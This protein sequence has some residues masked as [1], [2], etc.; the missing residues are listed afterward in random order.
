M[1]SKIR[2]ALHNCEK[3]ESKIQSLVK[4]VSDSK[5]VVPLA[6]TAGFI[7]TSALVGPAISSH[8]SSFADLAKA[9]A[10]SI[11]ALRDY[12][13]KI[14][15]GLAAG[16]VAGGAVL[17]AVGYLE[18][19]D[20]KKSLKVDGVDMSSIG[21]NVNEAWEAIVKTNASI[22][23]RVAHHQAWAI[24]VI[25]SA[26]RSAEVLKKHGFNPENRGAMID[27]Q[28]AYIQGV[29]YAFVVAR[30]EG[31]SAKIGAMVYDQ[32]T[33]KNIMRGML[34]YYKECGHTLKPGPNKTVLACDLVA[35]GMAAIRELGK[36]DM[37]VPAKA[38]SR[39]KPGAQ[40]F[41]R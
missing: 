20:E 10:D 15:Y 17:G 39:A 7:A 23:Q 31:R 6:L 33:N 36:Q 14:F 37:L 5:L 38:L 12:S 16:L 25:S 19:R 26:P 4:K 30:E 13:P 21:K 27:L 29:K 9:S 2:T 22:T 11:I 35:S 3:H 28:K 40:S 18:H 41:D 24:D 32:Y 1:T 34:N 8:L